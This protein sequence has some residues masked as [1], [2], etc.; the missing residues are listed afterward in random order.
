[1]KNFFNFFRLCIH[2]YETI[3]THHVVGKTDDVPVGIVY[4]NRCKHCGKMKQF[5][6]MG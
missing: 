6:V 1:M 2:Q 4:V 5:R 3:N